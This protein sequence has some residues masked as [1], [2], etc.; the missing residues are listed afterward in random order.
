MLMPQS[1]P[2]S[3]RTEEYLA[4]LAYV[5]QVNE[6]PAGSK[7]LAAEGLKDVRI[8]GRQAPDYVPD[9]ALVQV[10][11]CLTLG[12]NDSWLLTNASKPTM[13]LDSKGDALEQAAANRLAPKR[14]ESW[15]PYRRPYAH[16]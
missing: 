5:L 12:P 14:I 8:Y 10:L 1:S 6:F 13:T 3:L 7:D 4:I 11:A 9:F 2:G 15:H 16:L